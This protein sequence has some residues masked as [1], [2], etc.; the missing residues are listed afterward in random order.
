MSS[1]VEIKIIQPPD[2]QAMFLLRTI[3]KHENMS[4]FMSKIIQPNANAFILYNLQ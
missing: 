3:S 1:T 2:L 4:T